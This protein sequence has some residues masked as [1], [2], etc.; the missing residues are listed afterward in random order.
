MFR[1]GPRLYRAAV[2]ERLVGIAMCDYWARIIAKYPN[3][4]SMIPDSA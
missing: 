2:G 4:V 3:T 1:V